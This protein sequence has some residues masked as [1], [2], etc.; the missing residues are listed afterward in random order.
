MFTGKKIVSLVLAL[1]FVLSM[2]ACASTPA[3]EAVESA[4]AATEAV[5]ATTDTA[6]APEFSGEINIGQIVTALSGAAAMYGDYIVNSA[7]MAADE[8]NAAGGVNGKKLVITYY[9]DESQSTVALQVMQKL[10]SDIED[11]TA[12]LGPDWSGN[13]MACMELANQEGV[14]QLTSSK[15]RKITHQE[16]N[17]N[18]FRFVLSAD[19]VGMALAQMV[20][21]AGYQNV[22][23]W[24]TNSEYGLGGGEAAKKFCEELG[25]NVVS[26]QAH[27]SADT[28]FTAQIEDVKS[29]GAEVL[30]S[31]SIQNSGAASLKQLRESGVT[32]PVYGGDAMLTPDFAELVGFEYMDGVI[33]GGAFVATD[34][35][36]K[37]QTYVENYTKIYGNAPD[38]HGA[39][40]YDMVYVLAQAIEQY[41]E[42]ADQIREG[43]SKTAGYQG[44]SGLFECDEWGNMLHSVKI[45][46]FK[47]GEFQ[48]LTTMGPY[49]DYE[50]Q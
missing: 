33:C 41:G 32:I 1:L 28:D 3:A 44:V 10:L 15:A 18:I 19:F 11:I 13:T 4:P 22:A 29:S 47:D 43:L 20:K 42:S 12:V 36:E 7:Q 45:A 25:L 48:Y 46:E 14:P 27:E 37:T 30:I 9:D 49:A 50:N 35:D 17:D 38:D 21:D 26:Y 40:Y 23:I 5:A 39:A 24:Y 8:I 6:A 34:P 31:Y 2:T 16:N